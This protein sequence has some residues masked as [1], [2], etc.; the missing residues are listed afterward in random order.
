LGRTA[1]NAMRIAIGP[2]VVRSLN[3]VFTIGIIVIFFMLFSVVV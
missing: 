1:V 2:E 3:N